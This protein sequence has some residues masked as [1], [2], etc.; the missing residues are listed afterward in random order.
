MGNLNLQI[1][2]GLHPWRLGASLGDDSKGRS[3]RPNGWTVAFLMAMLFVTVH[4]NAA[5]GQDKNPFSTH[6]PGQDEITDIMNR[7]AYR[8]ASWGI[9]VVEL[10]T[11]KT[12]FE[13]NADKMFVPASTTKLF[14]VASAWNV[15][16]ADHTFQTP[17][18][19]NG[20]VDANGQLDGDL[21][22]IASG[23][24]TLGGRVDDQGR[25]AF[26]DTD[27]TYASNSGN[28]Q[29]TTPDP[30]AGLKDLARQV[31]SQGIHRVKGEVIIDDRLFQPSLSSGSGPTT[32]SPILVNDNVVDFVITPGGLDQ[33]ANVDWRPRSAA[34]SVDAQVMTVGGEEKPDVKVKTIDRGRIIVRGQIPEKREP[35][36]LITEVDDAASFARSLFV[37]A[38]QQ[39]GVEV[40]ASALEVNPA[41]RL[42]QL[43]KVAKLPAVATLKS[44]SFAEHARLILKVSHNLHA[45]T[46][47]LILASHHGE[48]T[49]AQG[50]RWQRVSLD[51][52]G[53][54]VASVSFGGGAGGTRSD[55]VTPQATVQLLTAMSKR[56]DFAMFREALPILG[57]DGTCAK[58]VDRESPVRGH[59]QAKTG[60]LY[61]DDLLNENTL[62][63]SKALAGYMTT[64]SGK[65]LAFAMFVN[66]VH[67]TNGDETSRIGKMLGEICE[68]GFKNW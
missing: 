49:L 54:D 14:T 11:G 24:L 23:D 2:C 32:V 38:L 3:R 63:T 45:S 26:Q 5:P 28:A 30:L 8:G 51:Q 15:L 39:A 41:T 31:K 52:L 59:V 21:I 19:R 56:S 27:H 1:L 68:V 6:Q 36:V 64:A 4:T 7:D 22:L 20:E 37:E 62:L 13:L 40:A 18:V 10:S 35:L 33:P 29:L 61:F 17:V 44:V 66:N 53:V 67:L 25:I 9:L 57:V 65:E 60:T 47:P 16:G 12:V 46:L 34:I 50:L 58:H 43:E 42:P 55:Y 48:R